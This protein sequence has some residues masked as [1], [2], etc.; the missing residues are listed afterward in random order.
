MTLS[1]FLIREIN[2]SRLLWKHRAK[3]TT[4]CIMEHSE[5]NNMNNE[6]QYAKP[7]KDIPGPKALP[8]LGNWFRF[9]PHIGEYGRYDIT[10]QFRMMRDQYGDI[11][12]LDGIL[13]HQTTVLLFSPELCEKMY[14]IEGVWPIRIG[15]ESMHHYRE[16]RKNIYN[17]Q[18]GLGTSQ[19]KA[20][21]DFRT[22][23][24]PYM[25]QP[26]AITAYVTQI[27][28]VAE[29]FVRK[30]RT[31]R[32]PKT[33]ELPDD[34]KNE[35]YKWALES[36]CSIA[37]D[38]RLG[39]LKSD[40]APD[41]EQQIM[42][43]SVHKMFDLMY[44]LDVLPSL[45]RLYNTRNLKEFFRVID[46]LNGIAIKYIDQA[47]K[48]LDETTDNDEN[49]HNSILQ[50]LL[51][52]DEQVA[53]VMALDMLTAGIDSTGNVVGGLLYY[54][55]NNP[56]KQEKLREEATAIL[57]DKTSSI[58][59]D[60][61]Q[62]L[63]YAKACVKESLRLFPAATGNLRTMPTDVC[64]GGYKIPAGVNVLACHSLITMEPTLFPRP[65]EYI[66]ERWMRGN[67]E[68]P[69]AQET[70]PFAYMPFGFGPR[71]CAGRRFAEMELETLLVT[72]IRNFRIEWHHEPLK[73]ES[74]YINTLAS[75]M[76]F[77][78]IDL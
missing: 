57:P 65:Q 20:W 19:G 27:S 5:T 41:S 76:R 32:D 3:S 45:W 8:L 70:H 54:I 28:E 61:L 67:T 52:L 60:I 48:K 47:K 73:Y 55:A 77:K 40:L 53:R 26:Q 39:C 1:R 71:S 72:V 38:C 4:A 15:M 29:E 17:G 10:T 62:Q 25:M 50:K 46:T 75:P 33:L 22:K 14:R 63:R 59:H 36:I 78:L 42:I 2:D 9:I 18:Y 49:S 51:R 66:P 12:K 6:L 30:M 56:E 7:T 43:N 64:I 34:F 23:I 69:S 37:L 74:R 44:R 21:Y 31:L 11:V 16:N 24:N 13:G 35:L 58:T 68:F